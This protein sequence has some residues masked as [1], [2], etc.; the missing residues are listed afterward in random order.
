MRPRASAV[1]APLLVALS[2]V[3]GGGVAMAANPYAGTA[4]RGR[5][6]NSNV[7]PTRANLANV[8]AA[9]LCLIDWERAAHGLG[10]LRPNGA[11]GQIASEQSADM[12]IGH[13]FGDNSLAGRTPWQRVLASPYGRR[14]KRLALGQNIGWGTGALA[15][16]AAIVAEWMRSIPHRRIMLTAAYHDIG[17]GV[18]PSAPHSANGATYTVDFATRG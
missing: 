12:V 1:L 4:R 6:H 9:T 15:T 5:C 11:L 3:A 8:T 17:V 16:P 18:A 13:Y 14:R 7:R 2:G 10:G